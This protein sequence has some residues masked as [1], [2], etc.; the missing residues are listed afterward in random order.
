MSIQSFLIALVTFVLPISLWAATPQT[1][2]RPTPQEVKNIRL[3]SQ[4]QYLQLR[5]HKQKINKARRRRSSRNTIYNGSLR[6]N[7]IRLARHYGWKRVVWSAAS[8]YNWVGTT[9]IRANSLP[10]LLSKLLRDYPLQAQFYKGNHVL[11]I[12]ARTL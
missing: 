8:D 1:S 4:P 12:V 6:T 11:V 2:A 3:K 9:R 5:L 10:N 7:I